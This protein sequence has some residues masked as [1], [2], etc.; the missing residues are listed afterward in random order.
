MSD[1][2]KTLGFSRLTRWIFEEYKTHGSIFGIPDTKFYR[3][4]NNDS[5]FFNVSMFGKTVET[6]F[7]PAAG[8][9]TQ[10]SQ[11]IIASYLTGARFIELKTVQ[12]IDDLKFEKPCIDAFD[13]GYNTEWSQEL[14]LQ[15]SFDEYLKSWILIHLLKNYLELSDSKNTA[16]FVFNMSVGYDLKGIQSEKMDGF[17]SRMIDPKREIKKYLEI[18][19]DQFPELFSDFN[20]G[21]LSNSVT[22]S[23][24]HGC[25]PEEIESMVQYLIREKGLN[26]YVKLNPTLPGKAAVMKILRTCGYDYIKIEDETFEHDLQYSDAVILIKNLQKFAGKHGRKFGIKLSNTLANKNI[27][28][29]LPGEE[30]Y[31][32]GRALFP[33][34]IHLA[35]QLASEF[36]GKINISYSGGASVVN[37]KDILGTGIYPVTIA[38]DILKPGGYMRFYQIAGEL[39]NDSAQ[40]PHYTLKEDQVHV[41]SLKELAQ[42]SLADAYYKKDTGK[43]HPIKVDSELGFFD[44]V[45]APCV[46]QCPIHQDIPEYIDFINKN[47][48]TNAL[49]T[50]LKKNPMPNITGYIC[51]HTCE[52]KCVRWDY[53]NP[54]NI[55]ELKRIAARRGEYCKIITGIKNEIKSK[56]KNRKVAVIGSGPA[57]LSAGFFLVGE[58]FEVTMFDTREKPG[59]TVR[60]AIPRFRLPDSVIDDDVSLIQELGVTIKTGCSREFSVEKLRNEGFDYLIITTGAGKPKELGI[61]HHSVKEGYYN[62]IEFLARIKNGEKVFIGKKVLIIGG[63]NSAVDAARTAVR[64][65]PDYVYIVYRRDLENMPADKVEVA[66]CFEEG[67]KIQQLLGPE[68]LIIENGRITG[69]E[70]TRMQPGEPDESGRPRP[71]PVKGSKITLEADTLIAA[72]GEEAEADILLQNKIKLGNGKTILANKS[73]GETNIPDVYAAGDCVRGPAAVVEAIADARKITS[74]ILEKEKMPDANTLADSCCTT[75]S[76]EKLEHSLSK[77]GDVCF[78][79]PVK[80]LPI[81]KRDISSTVIQTLTKKNAVG[82]SEKCLQCS[83]VCSKCVETCPNRANIALEFRPVSL[84]IPVFNLPSGVS[85]RTAARGCLLKEFKIK[86]ASQILHVDDF[87]NECGNCETF[88]PHNGKPYID[89]FTL[90]SEKDMFENSANS[91]FYLKSCADDIYYG[92]GCRIG[93]QCFDMLVDYVKKQ[94]AFLSSR[95]SVLFSILEEEKPLEL[96]KYSISGSGIPDMA[97]MLGLYFILETLLNKYTYI[98]EM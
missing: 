28:D 88:C 85:G 27:T 69:L 56:K 84:A 39:E 51:G 83:Q 2:M 52:G 43:I 62:G 22:I 12:V 13:E 92:F 19:Q 86:Q 93:N 97:D 21:S 91:G 30:R 78:S 44:C 14:S 63:G 26:T 37:I 71:V 89:K 77:H 65:N 72:V 73:T 54:V 75:I 42:K 17:I 74:A 81:A 7:G 82:E 1:K 48:Y 47:D 98:F 35:Y 58:G 40:T 67:I 9:H 3:H 34:T 15:Q 33:I 10:L 49:M 57:G 96:K 4:K 41:D 90:F 11:N 55:R 53:D 18:L 94:L 95:F 79:H 32:S 50:I 87:C 45:I 60:Y 76:E 66:A 24:M 6:P 29:V 36:E 23:T 25:P 68:K 38:T 61:D 16:G 59:G 70:C 8:P 5:A 64:F 80:K 31:M 20:T 46:K